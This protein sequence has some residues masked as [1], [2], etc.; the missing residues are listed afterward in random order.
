MRKATGSGTTRRGIALLGMAW[1]LTAR[2]GSAGPDAP[3]R[4]PNELF[5][6]GT[7]TFVLGT[8]GDDRSDAAIAAQAGMIRDLLF[9]AAPVVRDADVDAWPTSAVVYGGPH[10]NALV[11]RIAPTLPFRLAAGRLEIGGMTLEGDEHRLIALVPAHAGADSVPAHP[12]FLLYAGTGTPGITEIN[13]VRH[14]GQGVLVIDRFGPR[15]AGAWE[16]DGKGGVTLRMGTPAPRPAWRTSTRAVPP[17]APGR[18]AGEIGV[19]RLADAPVDEAREAIVDAACVRGVT[20]SIT[21]LGLDAPRGIVFHVYPDA[22]R[23]GAL[24][25]V[26]GDGHADAVSRTLHV[27]AAD[28][29]EGGALEHLVA[30]EATHVI[31]HDAWGAAGTP[32]FGEGLAVWASGTY[33][34]RTLDEWRTRVPRDAPGVADLLGPAFRKSPEA[35]AYPLAGLLVEALVRAHGSEAFRKH[36]LPATTRTWAQACRAAGTSPGEVEAL[37]RAAVKPR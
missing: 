25:S 9:P 2:A 4:T 16:D 20:R 23:K 13:G 29:S 8:A 24:T 17:A 7:P 27:V 21:A 32:L 34:G 26:R 3:P 19:A 11:A 35:V 5:A 15:V 22:A 28:P 6:R 31:A 10:V 30:H 1:A 37:Y 12:A 18:P 36:L 14:G 33:G